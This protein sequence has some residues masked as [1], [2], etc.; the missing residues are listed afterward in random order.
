LPGGAINESNPDLN[1]D[2]DDVMVSH[3]FDNDD[4]DGE[5]MKNDETYKKRNTV[6]KT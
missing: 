5:L 1:E 2:H 4:S 6:F 3:L